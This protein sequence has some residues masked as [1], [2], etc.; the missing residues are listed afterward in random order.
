MLGK[1]DNARVLGKTSDITN[2]TVPA[3]T[4]LSAPGALRKLPGAIPVRCWMMTV[5]SWGKGSSGQLGRGANQSSVNGIDMVGDPTG[6]PFEIYFRRQQQ[7]G[8][9]VPWFLWSTMTD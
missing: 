3:S 5:H 7:N 4:G 1:G 2:K 9:W 6:D 8:N